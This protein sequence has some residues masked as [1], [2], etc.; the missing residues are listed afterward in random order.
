MGEL[1]S[2]ISVEQLSISYLE[3]S[4]SISRPWG[5]SRLIHAIR[6]VSLNI[7]RGENVAL[8]GRNGAGKSTLLKA[9]S[10]LIRPSSGKISTNGRV[11]LLS[12]TDP[13]F[14]PSMSGRENLTELAL[15]YGINEERMHEF[16]STVQEFA[17]IGEAIDRNVGG[18]ST[19]MK[20]KLGFGFI[21]SLN[22][23]ILLI[24]ETLGVGDRVFRQKAQLRLR[25]FIKRS[26]TVIISTHSLG[27]AKEICNKGI[28]L[29]GGEL[30]LFG[31]IEETIT[32]YVELTN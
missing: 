8:I 29:E 13:G 7:E 6:N 14:I 18:Y 24:D 22:P 23:E 27:M 5:I 4:R 12:G 25:D 16:S 1:K 3:H 20:G 19:G 17:E 2:S 28:L 30:E 26:G 10:G 21:T 15:A 32:R 31:G 11:V 9:I